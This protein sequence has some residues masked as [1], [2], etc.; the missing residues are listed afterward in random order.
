[1]ITAKL[2]FNCRNDVLKHKKTAKKSSLFNK[3]L[4]L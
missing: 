1:M 4:I 2:E 3:F